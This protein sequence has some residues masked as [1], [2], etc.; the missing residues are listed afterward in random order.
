MTERRLEVEA[1]SR[2]GEG[3]A[4]RDGAR[5]LVPFALPGEVVV[6]EVLDGRARLVGVER[7]SPD[8][9]VPF[10][11]YHG[12]CGG[13]Q[14]QHFAEDAYRRW[15]RSLV[16]TALRRHGINAPAGDLIDAHGA[17]RRRVSLHVR[18]AAG[19]VIAGFMAPRSHRLLDIEGCPAAVPALARASEIARAI[20]GML[21]AC[22]VMLTATD[23]GIDAAVKAERRVAEARL[24]R[25]AALAAGHDL[26]RLTVN[27]D[28]VAT[29]R[30][31]TVMMGPASVSLPP[32]SFL[33][34]TAEGELRLAEIVV[35][36][37]GK[38]QPV[39]DLYCGCGPFALR[40][41][42]ARRVAACDSDGAAIAALVQ[43]ARAAPGL[44]PI[45]AAVRNLTREPLTAAELNGIAAVVFDP[46]RA[47]AEAQCRHIANSKVEVV[48]AVSCDPATLARDAAILVGGGYIVEAITPVDQFKW[49]SH[50]ETVALFR[51]RQSLARST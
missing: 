12:K 50:V 1:L 2:R 19:G 26:A 8:R 35:T 11:R 31:A 18:T 42:A 48:V 14:L 4:D 15:K 6:A 49:T 34:A 23:G 33:Q 7:S 29:R 45:A 3:V 9:V 37:V 17:G 51:R 32:G 40:L 22:D 20:G 44:K 47:G 28:V 25:L 38:A 46:P 36:A 5:V 27:G 21:G 10:C 43:A 13:C 41:A 16:E 30:P 39:A 24:P